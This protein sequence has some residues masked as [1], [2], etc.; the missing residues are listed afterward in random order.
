MLS[1]AM[2]IKRYPLVVW[3]F[4]I[5][6]FIN[7]AGGLMMPLLSRFLNQNCNFSLESI[8]WIFFFLGLGSVIGTLY[9]GKLIDKFGAYKVILASL[10]SSSFFLILMS[11]VTKFETFCLFIFL[12]SF[13]SDMLRPAI[14][15]ILKDYTSIEERIK[16][17]TLIRIASNLGL[18]IGPL[19]SSYI[20]LRNANFGIANSYKL[21]FFLDAFTC[22]VASVIIAYFIQERR[23]KFKLDESIN[24]KFSVK[25]APLKDKVF[26]LNN[27]V[28]CISGIL[29]F[30]FFSVFPLYYSKQF[31][32]TIRVDYLFSILAL[33][34]ALFELLFVNVYLKLKYLNTL[35][36]GLGLGFFILGYLSLYF[37]NGYFGVF[38]YVLCIGLGA[39][40]TFPFS[41]NIVVKR[42][43]LHQEGIFM[44]FFQIS[45]GFS[46]MISGKLNTFLV[47]GWGFS[48]NW[49]INILLALIGLVL[50]HFIYLS[51]KKE[52]IDLENRLSSYF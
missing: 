21:I 32:S 17:F 23:L 20:I 38:L 13:F 49:N 34:I 16:S 47:E 10:L 4:F 12:F 1:V 3:Y 28:A 51:L 45:Y 36:I 15:S 14:F 6:V 24:S 52:K 35:V 44:A 42:S 48:F 7:K 30:Q 37:L 19:I 11:F 39:V 31:L 29:F 43:H 2:R 46:Q 8:G 33:I 22:F 25:L 27:I 9:S 18:I 50:N 26:V 5:A 40:H 41:A